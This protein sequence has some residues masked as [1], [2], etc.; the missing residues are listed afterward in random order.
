MPKRT[1]P[2][3]VEEVSAILRRARTTFA[4]LVQGLDV[5]CAQ[6][7]PDRR[8]IQKCLGAALDGISRGDA[9]YAAKYAFKLGVFVCELR[10]KPLT[11]QGLRFYRNAGAKQPGKGAL[12][13]GRPHKKPPGKK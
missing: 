9:E 12:P 6:G 5:W 13:R 2:A 3:S 4:D 10:Y 11:D 1:R 7:N 8:L